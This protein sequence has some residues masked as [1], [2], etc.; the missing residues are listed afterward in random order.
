MARTFVWRESK[1]GV[2]SRLLAPALR[3]SERRAAENAGLG[4]LTGACVG[5]C[6]RGGS[7]GGQGGSNSNITRV[8]SDSL[9]LAG[10]STA[11]VLLKECNECR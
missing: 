1:H 8:Q 11:T 10:W 4:R 3:H 5:A 2:A 9:L 6:A 7:G